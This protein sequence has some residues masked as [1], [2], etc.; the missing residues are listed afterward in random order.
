MSWCS[1]SFTRDKA[2][3]WFATCDHDRE[4]GRAYDMGLFCAATGQ[5]LGGAGINQLATQ[6]AKRLPSPQVPPLNAEPE[7][8]SS[9]MTSPVMHISIRLRP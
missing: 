8:V 9:F 7:I 6:P 4:A 3:A 5:L 2:L 1:H